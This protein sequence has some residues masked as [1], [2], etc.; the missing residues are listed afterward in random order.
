MHQFEKL[1]LWQQDRCESRKLHGGGSSDDGPHLRGLSDGRQQGGDYRLV[2]GVGG[3]P[4]TWAQFE[5][6]PI[7]ES[8]HPLTHGGVDPKNWTAKCRIL[9]KSHATEYEMT[10]I[11][12]PDS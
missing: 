4:S 1:H 12:I 5:N 8:Y 10:V 11:Y 2:G 3:V 9:D 6:K 7:K